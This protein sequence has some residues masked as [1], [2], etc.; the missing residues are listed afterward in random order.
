MRKEAAWKAY[1]AKIKLKPRPTLTRAME[2][3][4]NNKPE[5]KSAIDLGCGNGND[6]IH[7][8]KNGW[9]VYAI[10]ASPTAIELVNKNTSPPDLK[11]L[12]TECTTFD[13]TKWK[14]VT[15]VNASLSLPFCKKENFTFVWDNI[16]RSI[17]AGGIFAGHFFGINDDWNDL[18]LFS[19]QELQN[20]FKDF[21]IEFFEGKEFDK[22]SATGPMKHWHIFEVLAVKK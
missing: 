11:N 9:Q 14:P 21:M 15:F 10:D 7:L 5:E 3:F 19:E 13:E 2:Y 1:Y 22:P 16:V 8:L 18:N 4:E 17:K 6:T 20:L 12:T